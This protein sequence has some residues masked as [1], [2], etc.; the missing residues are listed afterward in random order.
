MASDD[1]TTLLPPSPNP[2]K[3]DQ[4]AAGRPDSDD[5]PTVGFSG[6]QSSIPLSGEFRLTGGFG[7]YE[8]LD[9]IARG[10]MGV[11]YRARQK[12]LNRVVALKMILNGQFASENDVRRFYLEAEAAANLDHRGIVPIFDVGEHEGHHFFSMK[13][14][15]GGSL[16]DKL[17]ELRDKTRDFVRLLIEVARAIHHAHQRGILHRDLKPT[18][19][20]I[21]DAGQPLVSD[22]GLAKQITA[23]SDL[24]NTGAAVGTPA[25]MPPEQAAGSKEITTAADIF[26]LGAMLYEGLTGRP[27]HQESTP[28]K[29]LLKALEGEVTPPRV[30]DS[31]VDRTL[32]LITLRCLES[33]PNLRYASAAALADDLKRWLQG[34]T[35]SVRRPSIGSAIT[36]VL[37]ANLRSAA[38]AA[39]IGLV[40]GVA[41][42]WCMSRVYSQGDVRENPPLAIYEELS[43]PIPLGRSL[44]FMNEG[45]S[46]GET[47]LLASVGILAVIV[48]TGILVAR[49]TRAKPGSEAFSF[50]LIAALFMTIAMFTLCLGFSLIADTHSETRSVVALL[51]DAAFGADERADQ[52][53][54][55]LVEA[56]PQL[57]QLPERDRANTLAYRV[58]Y[59][60]VFLIPI[61]VLLGIVMSSALCLTPC[62]A[63]TTFASKLIQERTKL[64]RSGLVYLEF[65]AVTAATTILLFAFTL[66]FIGELKAFGS[67]FWPMVVM[68][69][70]IALLA[71]VLTVLFRRKLTWRGRLLIYG[72]PLAVLLVLFLR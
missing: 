23:E 39:V 64:W 61:H 42:S 67:G 22:L 34:E 41:F 54:Q 62:I 32:E 63:G 44:A 3:P 8:L 27:P 35:V 43:A 10:G 72:L 28:V 14:V 13:L 9:E 16:A 12:S 48:F 18:N 56:Y 15:E 50:G 53:R 65:M 55:Q 36:Q 19:I 29:T 25:Y 17:P 58:H 52:A 68:T 2:D 33:D 51:T 59:D 11:V 24:T 37:Q 38:G 31:R 20:L 6:V 5:R 66:A 21:D 40:A 7:D 4:D 45:R 30:L 70:T 46:D 47:I 26:S 1:P 71:A 60:S 49:T 57:E 69:G